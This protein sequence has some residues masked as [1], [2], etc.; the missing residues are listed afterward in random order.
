MPSPGGALVNANAN[1]DCGALPER[2]LLS[3]VAMPVVPVVPVR[4]V[5]V[6]AAGA[7][8]RPRFSWRQSAEEM[9]EMAKRYG[10]RS[11]IRPGVLGSMLTAIE[12]DPMLVEY[13]VD[14]FTNGFDVL[15]QGYTAA[16]AVHPGDRPLF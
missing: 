15:A 12:Y 9:V 2:T 7:A 10:T 11:P 1:A 4:A 6:P 5:F 16:A 8:A 3:V 14:G 13:L